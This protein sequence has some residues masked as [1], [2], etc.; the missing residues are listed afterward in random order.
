MTKTVLILSI[1]LSSKFYVS[2]H[3]RASMHSLFIIHYKIKDAR[4]SKIKSVSDIDQGKIYAAK[5][6]SREVHII[7]RNNV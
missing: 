2:Y 5:P 7:I 4:Y 3:G 6:Y 1:W